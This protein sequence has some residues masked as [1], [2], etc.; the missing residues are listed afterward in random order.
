MS[1]KNL[2]PEIVWNNF[3]ELTKIPRPSKKEAKVADYLYN[4][5]KSHGLETV[6]DEIGNIIIRKGATPGYENLKGV[7]LQGHMDMVP[8]KNNDVVHDFEKDPIDAYVDGEWVRAR[9]TTLG[10]DNGIGV[11]LALSVLESDD[12]KHGP[13]E[14][15]VTTDEETGM[16]GAFN[17]KPDVLKGEILINLDSETEGELYVGCAGG[18]D[19]NAECDYPE[20]EI[21]AGWKVYDVAVKGFKGGHS[22]MDI[23]LCRAN[24]NKVAARVLYALLT[25]AGVKLIDF[26]GGTLRNAI[27]REAFATVAVSPENEAKAKEAFDAVAAVVKAE[28]AGTDPDSEFIFTPSP[29]SCHKCADEKWALKLVEAVIACPDGVERMSSEIPGLVETSNNLAMVSLAGGKFSVKTLMRSSV[30]S[31]KEALAD[32]FTCVFDLAGIPTGFTG[33]YSGWAPNSH[34]EI[35]QLMTE[36]YHKLYGKDPAVMAI[37]AGLECGILGGIY[38]NWDMISCGPTILS[39]HSPDERVNIATVGKAWDFLKAVLVSI[40]EK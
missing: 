17:L 26:V 15:L 19:A 39:P 35:R 16:T 10:A 6:K 14:V 4:W 24:A 23:I 36:V 21:P 18:I 29:K 20:T 37:H 30:D 1:I 33:G 32:R 2:K 3:H 25:K 38:P 8:Q 5:G 31:A 13:V 9:G 40:P 34:S 12:V 27:P 22:G 11:S 7:I 28:Y